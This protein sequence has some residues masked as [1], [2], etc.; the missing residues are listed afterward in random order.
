MSFLSVI[1][2]ILCLKLSEI[3]IYQEEYGRK[4]ILLL[5]DIFSELDKDKKKNIIKYIDKELQVFITSTD[6]NNIDKKIVK[7]ATIFKIDN[8]KVV[9][10]E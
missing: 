1:V 4:P 6:L 8:G 2:A 7:N 3:K 10:G 9:E 5:D